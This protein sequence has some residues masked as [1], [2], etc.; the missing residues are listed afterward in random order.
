MSLDLKR[1][2]FHYSEAAGKIVSR[3][4][5]R[6]TGAARRVRLDDVASAA[7][8]STASVSLV[9]R[10]APGPSAE[11]R[12]RV[13]ETARRLGYRPDRAASLLASR[14]SR[15]IGLLID[16]RSPFH[17][18]VAEQVLDRA[19]GRGYDLVL[20]TITRRRGEDRAVETLLDSRCEGLLLIG[21][22]A[23]VPRLAALAA[24]VPVVVLCR[25]LGEDADGVDVVRVPDTDGTALAVDHLHGLGH[26]DIAYLDAGT[27][28][29]AQ[30]RREGYLG[31]MRARGLG[32]SIR[33]LPGADGTETTGID[34]TRDL[35][36]AD[37]LPTAVVAFND[38]CAVGLLDALQRAGVDVPGTISVMGYDDDPLSRMAHV[39]LTTVGQDTRALGEWAVDAVVERL[40]GARAGH[41]E[42]ILAPYLAVRGTTGPPGH[43]PALPH[44]PAGTP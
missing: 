1:F 15:L 40:D 44:R 28:T 36:A 31:A 27:G 39:N 21:P 24:S 29:I 35:L 20:S 25:R 30:D 2:K 11:T 19:E 10:N 18:E 22:D 42:E 12:R 6:M 8:V 4:S 37:T 16:V 5:E 33:V 14:R 43:R 32:A 41:R 17:A 13:L 23:P 26:S 3:G 9:L 38:R 7:G 34:A